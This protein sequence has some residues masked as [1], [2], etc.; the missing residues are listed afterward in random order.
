MTKFEHNGW[1]YN[2]LDVGTK[3]TPLLKV[4]RT[5]GTQQD[6]LHFRDVQLCSLAC[7]GAEEQRDIIENYFTTKFK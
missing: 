2:V 7:D 3:N 5:R 6:Y 4:Y 1:Q